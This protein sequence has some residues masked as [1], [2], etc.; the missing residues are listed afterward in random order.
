MRAG[1]MGAGMQSGRFYGKIVN[2]KTN[3]GIDA[4][5]VQLMASKFDPATKQR[6]DTLI[7]GML[8]QPNGDF[9]L[10]NVP[11]MGDYKLKISAIG[12]KPQEEK[13]SFLA[14]EL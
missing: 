12:F 1:G 13:I 3:K 6:K 14:P 8:T 9:F 7:N 4:A 10:E 11:F 2:E 5:S